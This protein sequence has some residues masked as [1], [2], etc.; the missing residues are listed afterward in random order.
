MTQRRCYIVND[1]VLLLCGVIVVSAFSHLEPGEVSSRV[2][3]VTGGEVRHPQ[4]GHQGFLCAQHP[5]HR[6]VLILQE[7]QGYLA[8]AHIQTQTWV[9][10][11]R[12]VQTHTRTHTH[13]Q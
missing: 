3:E 1:S 9:N 13:A 2:V 10:E 8:N 7:V 6:N 4:L 5:P 11:R 12:H